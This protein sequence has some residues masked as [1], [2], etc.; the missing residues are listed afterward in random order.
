MK[1]LMLVICA[2]GVFFHN[3]NAQSKCG[4][5]YPSEAGASRTLTMY[6]DDDNE[7]GSV[8]YTVKQVTGDQMT[9]SVEMS[10]GGTA[11]MQNEYIMNCTDD[12]VS[13]DF[14]SMGGAMISS[15]RP[16]NA[17]ITGTD[18][19]LPN[20]LSE[21][22]I[23]DDAEMVISSSMEDEDGTVYNSSMTMRMHDR[24]VDGIEDISTPAGDFENCYRI[25]YYTEMSRTMPTITGVT[26][27]VVIFK[28]KTIQ[29]LKEGIGVVKTM[30]YM[31]EVSGTTSTWS[32]QGWGQLTAMN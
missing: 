28:S 30:D 14:N 26:S 12:G 27:T 9:Y 20:V 11:M 29:W 2:F 18:I 3:A 5:F 10:R 31:E 24:K 25:V 16:D 22:Q 4:Y 23:L 8:T 6:D 32:R 13:I 21:G 7:Q 1:N 17:T 19:Y 15:M